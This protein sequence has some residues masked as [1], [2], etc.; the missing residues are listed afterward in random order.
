MEVLILH[1]RSAGSTAFR[2][3]ENDDTDATELTTARLYSS[4]TVEGNKDKD[5]IRIVRDMNR[6]SQFNL[7]PGQDRH[8]AE[9]KK[10]R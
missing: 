3:A 1:S 4:R 10:M 9:K 5:S 6:P 7:G 2:S 8:K